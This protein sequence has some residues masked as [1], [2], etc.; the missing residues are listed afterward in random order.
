MGSENVLLISKKILITTMY[1]CIHVN[2]TSDICTGSFLV[3]FPKKTFYF[4]VVFYFFSWG[5][6][7]AYSVI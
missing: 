6:V 2:F 5:G 1:M 7:V 4:D 3:L